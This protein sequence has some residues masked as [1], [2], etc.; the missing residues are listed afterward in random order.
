[1]F[2]L[3]TDTLLHIT[4]YIALLISI[5]GP[6]NTLLLVSG[7]MVGIVRTLPLILAEIIGYTLAIIV[8]GIF[9]A[10]LTEG[11]PWLITLVKLLCALY[12]AWMAIKMWRH[13][14]LE[15]HAEHVRPVH[16]RDVL[17]TTLLNPKAL[18]FASAIFPLSAFQRPDHFL[19]SMAALLV[20]LIPSAL[21]W[22]AFGRLFAGRHAPSRKGR[23]IF[24]VVSALTLFLFAMLLTVSAFYPSI[25]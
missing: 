17:L 23:R 19:W 8:W 25:L 6:T 13:S 12:I 7:M 5:P 10:A 9:L 15:H 22:S 11:H 2:A 24:L 21:A 18:V 14:R 4:L 16:F 3:A 1:M 20:A